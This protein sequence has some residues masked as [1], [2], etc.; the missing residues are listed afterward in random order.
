MKKFLLGFLC[1]AIFFSGI[2]FAASGDLIAK[3]SNAKIFINKEEQ[4]MSTKPVIINN[5]TYLPLR[6]LSDITGY[7]VGVKEGDIYLSLTRYAIDSVN[8]VGFTPL[9]YHLYIDNKLQKDV[10]TLTIGNRVMATS[11]IL[12]YLWPRTQWTTDS[13][14]N[15]HVYISKLGEVRYLQESDMINVNGKDIRVS[16]APKKIGG[17]V[18]LPLE[19][20]VKALGYQINFDQKLLRIDIGSK[21]KKQQGFQTEQRED[22]L[23]IKYS[24]DDEDD[25]SSQYSANDKENT[26]Q[27]VEHGDNISTAPEQTVQNDVSGKIRELRSDYEKLERY[28]N[29][30]IQAIQSEYPLASRYSDEKYDELILGLSKEKLDIQSKR[31]VLALDDSWE[32]KAKKEK[33]SQQID[34]LQQ[35]IEDLQKEQKALAR[36]NAMKQQLAERKQI[37]DQAIAELRK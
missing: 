15:E 18:Y 29:S 21:L 7:H 27:P 35:Q 5:T 11:N 6:E 32:A 28:I 8:N 36:I 34:S 37:V 31:N 17:S 1:G 9:N 13:V 10:Y 22:S 16:Q 2:S 20:V 19:D 26:V 30:Q 23:F 4:Y 24:T 12:L 33:Y 14:T 25:L 3:T